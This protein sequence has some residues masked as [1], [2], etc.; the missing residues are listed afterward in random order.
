MS[1]TGSRKT[2]SHL[3][4]AR[5]IPT[6]YEI[7]TSRLL[8]YYDRGG[9]AVDLP[10]SEWYRR[11]QVGSP[12]GAAHPA[13]A[14]PGWEAFEDPRATTYSSYVRQQRDRE[15]FVARVLDAASVARQDPALP[16]AWIE[17]LDRTLSPLRFV[18]H[19]LQMAAAYVAQMAPSGRITVAALFQTGD[20]MRRIHGIAFRV[21]QLRAV[22]GPAFGESGR[23]RWQNDPSWQPLRRTI[24]TL[25]VTYDW[26]AA[27]VALNVCV[28]PLIDELF[29][30]GLATLAE[31]HGDYADAQLLRSL[32]DDSTWQR[33]WTERLLRVA[34]ADPSGASETGGPDAGAIQARAA[35]AGWIAEWRPQIAE[36]VA[37][38][39]LNLGPDGAAI[40]AHAYEV[41]EPF[42]R[43][44]TREGRDAA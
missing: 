10:T 26:G 5:R 43:P 7:V 28:R 22:A 32:A 30:V 12:I 24:E 8:Y 2:Y 27:L 1:I 14:S 42:V 29:L 33:E 6:T 11:H 3:A 35:I 31:R 20:E 19:G 13:G 21:V 38:A 23:D 34:G 17:T 40:A 9:F 36:A 41:L 44:F 25:L 15:A 39:A 37:A 16:A 18:Y 4:G